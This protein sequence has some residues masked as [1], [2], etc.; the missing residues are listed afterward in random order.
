MSEKSEAKGGDFLF[1]C[2]CEVPSPGDIQVVLRQT[3][4]RKFDLSLVLGIAERCRFGFPR[5]AVCSPLRGCA[6][7]PT[8]FWLTCPWLMHHIGAVEAEGGVGK[9]GRWLETYAPREWVSFNAEHQR[10]RLALLPEAE[11]DLL[12]RCQSRTFEGLHGGVGG[13]R[14]AKNGV[15]VKC[16]HLQAAS[17]LAL[18]HH[19]GQAWLEAHSA[20]QT[21]RSAMC[22]AE[23]TVD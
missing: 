16:V 10:L 14:Y 17:W 15:R 13:I 11:K 4:S 5:V 23:R 3:R 20:G 18:G 2:P 12:R 9:L 6:P 19:P 8:T 22:G 1:F 21:C 7:F